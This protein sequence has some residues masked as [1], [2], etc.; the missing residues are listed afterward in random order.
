MLAGVKRVLKNT[1][2][3]KAVQKPVPDLIRDL[4]E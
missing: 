3:T 2:F 1:L 4:S